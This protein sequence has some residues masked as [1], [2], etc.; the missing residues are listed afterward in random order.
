MLPLLYSLA[1]TGLVV[2]LGYFTIETMLISPIRGIVLLLLID[3]LLFLLGT[4]AVRT[5][6]EICATLFKVQSLMVDMTEGVKIGRAH[7]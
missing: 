7:V 1:I 3:P 4:A 6:L 2:T 5:V